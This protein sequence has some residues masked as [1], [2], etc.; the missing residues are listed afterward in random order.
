MINLLDLDRE[1]LTAFFVELGEKPFRATQIMK[2]IYQQGVFDFDKMTNLSKDL[3]QRLQT[4]ACLSLPEIQTE[5]I[6]QD[7]T[8]KWLVRLDSGNSIEM[9]LIPEEERN[10][11]C[12]SSQVGCALDC[13][14]CATGKQ[15]F[16]RNLT[17]AEIVGQLWLA[18]QIVIADGQVRE[19]FKHAITNVVIMGMGEPLINF[20]NTVK[21]MRIMLDDFAYGLS[22]RRITLSTVGIV[23]ALQR[24]KEQCPVSL[25]ISL[26]APNDILRNQLIPINKKYPLAELINTCR[27]YAQ[28][29]RHVTFEYVMLKN[30]NDSITHAHELVKL[31][32]GIPAKINLIPFNPFPNINYQRSAI[33]DIDNF[34]NVLIQA[35]LVTVTRKIRG[36]DIN[37][38]CGQLAGKI[39]NLKNQG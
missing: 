19:N 5:Q 7:G 1:G 27:D 9:V 23:P 30:I 12:I 34:R 35:G 39:Q 2:W 6:S 28:G 13:T 16:N 21:A 25:A 4:I 24:L 8:R 37:A 31:L 26:H 29:N 36:D 20:D 33:E 17:T 32:R 38:A 22:R 18:E 3:R 11:L 10:T 14:F 15:G